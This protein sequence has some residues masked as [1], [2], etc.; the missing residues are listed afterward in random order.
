MH[1][2]GEDVGQ[3]K[4]VSA[5]MKS[6]MDFTMGLAKGFHNAP[7]LYGDDTVR[8]SDKITGVQSGLVAAAKE[9]HYGF[10]DGI[11][12]LVTQPLSGAKKEGAAGFVKGAAKGFGGLILKPG[13]GIW[14]LPGYTF[15]GIYAELQKH[16]GSSVQ[17]Y[18]IAARTA[19]GY[20]EWKDSTPDQR[21][22]I[23]NAWKSAQ[24]ELRKH[25]KKYGKEKE[26]EIHELATHTRTNSADVLSGFKHTRHMSWDERKKLDAERQ[27]LKEE[28]KKDN[29]QQRKGSDGTVKSRCKY[30][31]FHHEAGLHHS[32]SFT[33]HEHRPS[34]MDP[35][36]PNDLE[37]AIQ[38]SVSATSRGDPTEDAIIERAL[39]ASVRELQEA[40][41]NGQL[42]DDDAFE[43]AVAVS[44]AEAKRA[45]DEATGGTTKMSLEQEA[46]VADEDEDLALTKT[47]T[48]SL[49]EYKISQQDRHPKHHHHVHPDPD[50][51][52][53]WSSDSGLGTDEDEDFKRTLEESKRMHTEAESKRGKV[54]EGVEVAS[55][56]DEHDEELKRAVTESENAH[57]L[58]QDELTRQKTEEEIVMD[59]MKKQS[60][61]E[62][63]HR[64]KLQGGKSAA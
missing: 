21:I 1:S 55:P 37:I 41:S 14:G 26:Q 12:G 34:A 18:I 64:Q 60:L 25:G 32:Q 31:P 11:T 46:G 45:R 30:C 16:F 33:S 13:A 27:R 17:N 29:A 58:H 40:Q 43:R 28:R 38:R 4:I 44:V 54:T 5:G 36:D 48:Q 9:F 19:Q 42:D 57:K 10:Y 49:E 53:D 51:L 6:P 47:L 24:L 56:V 20:E 7:K 63:Q 35:T 22:K 3:F 61:L 15:K 50:R 39:R 59:Y 23:I 62:E 8:K 52:H 2:P